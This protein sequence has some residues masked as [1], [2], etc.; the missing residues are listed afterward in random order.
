MERR[1][2]LTALGAGVAA[3]SGCSEGESGE[4]EPANATATGTPA[5]TDTPETTEQ[6]TPEPDPSPTVTDAGLLLEQGQ[7]AD[8]G[9]DIEGIGQGGELIVGIEFELPVSGG[10]ARG[11]VQTNIRDSTDSQ[12]T[13][14]SSEIDAVVGD[15]ADS[16]SRQAWF[17]FDTESWDQGSYTAELL[18]N[19]ESYGTTAASEVAFDIVEPLGEGEVELRL[20]EYPDEVVAGEPFDLTFGF[21]NLTDRDTSLATDTVTLDPARAD[22]VVLNITHRVNIPAG[23]EGLVENEDNQLSYSGSYTYRIDEV[24]EEISFTVQPPE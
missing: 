20:A 15:D 14:N 17:A 8:L 9:R 23:E 12:I 4:T 2:Y 10:A 11:V 22:P 1:T 7:Y 21:R 6:G 3:V 19:S 13:R 5:T 18:V 24:D 16:Q